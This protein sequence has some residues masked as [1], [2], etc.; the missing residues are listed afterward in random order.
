LGKIIC[1]T[2]YEILLDKLAGAWY[3]GNF[4]PGVRARAAIISHYA[5]FVNRQFAQK[6]SPQKWGETFSKK[7]GF[8]CLFLFPQSQ[9]HEKNCHHQE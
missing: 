1:A 3:N 7:W 8:H 2:F 4:G 5:G 9:N 6:F